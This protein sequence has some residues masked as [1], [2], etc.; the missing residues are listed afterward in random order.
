[1]QVNFSNGPIAYFVEMLKLAAEHNDGVFPSLL[2]G[3][4][5]LADTLRR[6]V[7]ALER[8]CGRNSPEM[9]MLERNI[10]MKKEGAFAFLSGL[11][12][13]N[14][15]HYAGKDVKLYTPGKPVFWYKS[16]GAETYR[17]IFADL[18]IKALSLA[19]FQIPFGPPVK[20]LGDNRFEV[21]F[22]YRPSAKVESVCLAGS[23][24][25]W[26]PTAQ[27]MGGPD[28]VGQF[29]TRLKLR[30][31]TYE[32]KFVVNGQTWKPDP[33][34]IWQSDPDQNSEVHV[35][36]LFG[37][38]AKPLGDDQFEVT[39]RYR[40]GEKT[41]SVYLAG[42]FN[43]WKATGHKMDGPDRE[44]R[45]STRLRLKKGSYEYKFVVDGQTWKTDPDNVWRTGPNQNSLLYV[46]VG[47]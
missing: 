5:G 20:P 46:G 11:S 3:E 34:N 28:Q 4:Q 8:K 40:P 23:F 26:N 6:A 39:F 21:T 22:S 35:G 7:K 31:G 44:G 29:S 1:M 14:D 13:E 18:T 37:S 32:Y 9:F 43:D 38:P 47:P 42:S 45:F 2:V 10:A 30:K 33:N 36:I 41:K 25:G 12:P 27:K 16:I 24:N 15:W 19:A 17:V